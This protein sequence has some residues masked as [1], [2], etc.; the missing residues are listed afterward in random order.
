MEE[1]E[2]KQERELKKEATD[3]L[4]ETKE[5]IKNINIKEEAQKGKGLVGK[6][7]KDSTGT[8][9]EIVKDEKNQ[10]YKTAILVVCIWIVIV[11]LK[12]ILSCIVYEFHTFKI[13]RTIKI[14]IAP[15][16]K[17]IA[18]SIIIHMLN[19]ENKQTLTKAITAVA[20]AKIPVV[21]SSCLGFLTYI[22]SNIT[23]ITN[24]ISSLLSIISTILMFFVVKEMF[25]EENEKALKTFIKVEAIYYIVV[26]AFSFLGISL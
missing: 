25:E 24:P 23:Y 16:L 6:L 9:K 8:I 22:S 20:I 11:L 19:K 21:I 10:F 26:F 18:M 7:L 12:E 17:I 5:Q 15:I 1:N 2:E 14:I 4:N 3:T 13:L